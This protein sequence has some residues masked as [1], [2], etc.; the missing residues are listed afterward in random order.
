MSGL[1][2]DFDFCLCR[3]QREALSEMTGSD[4][5]PNVWLKGVYVGGC[6]DGPKPWMGIKKIIK[7]GQL[8]Q[9]LKRMAK[10]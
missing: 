8:N 6:N 7:S 9:F 5:I 3:P 2:I 4:S 1:P 10:F